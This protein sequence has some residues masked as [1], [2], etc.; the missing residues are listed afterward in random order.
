MSVEG[1]F[2]GKE[3]RLHLVTPG[4]EVEVSG[5]PDPRAWVKTASGR[6]GT[7]PRLSIRRALHPFGSRAENDEAAVDWGQTEFFFPP[8]SEYEAAVRDYWLS[9]P[10]DVIQAVKA[11]HG[12][13]SFHLAQ[14][15]AAGGLDVLRRLP[16]VGFMGAL[17]SPGEMEELAALGDI[18]LATRLGLSHE[19]REVLLDV[20]GRV[21]AEAVT[22]ETVRAVRELFGPGVLTPERAEGL[23]HERR[24]NLG[25]LRLVL[26]DR[27]AWVVEP[28]LVT[29]VAE[30][31]AEDRVGRTAAKIERA[32]KLAEVVG[33]PGRVS[34]GSF[35]E[36]DEFLSCMGKLAG[37]MHP[38]KGPRFGEAPVAG[39]H[40]I[41]VEIG[42]IETGAALRVE[43]QMMK[44]CAGQM[45]EPVLW[46]H[47][48]FY[49]MLRPERV[50]IK[51]SRMSGGKWYAED[52]RTVENA[53]P[54]RATVALIAYWLSSKQGDTGCDDV[55]SAELLEYVGAGRTEFACAM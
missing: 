11:F 55:L 45:M 50:S 32:L 5:W 34:F 10:R 13:Y 38:G 44:N 41:P 8:V 21:P 53:L 2:D 28:W 29:R 18:D 3:N 15:C 22:L 33:Q 23:R 51:L 39:V 48:Y 30:W 20:L 46:G 4:Q 14:W 27:F 37:T 6:R 40:S 17:W 9:F 7:R 26:L 19:D 16:V 52:A 43:G 24:L 31:R 47:S 25:V 54:Q 1:R 49:R 36:V 42:P 12:D 35:E